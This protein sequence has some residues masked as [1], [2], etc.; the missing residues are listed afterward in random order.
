MSL[1][2]ENIEWEFL[3]KR[4][5]HGSQEEEETGLP[6]SALLAILTSTRGEKMALYP[7]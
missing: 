3:T 1:F 6:L 4:E 7:I 5:L 2:D